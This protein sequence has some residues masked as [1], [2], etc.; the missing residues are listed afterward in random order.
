MIC[1]DLGPSQ[2]VNGPNGSFFNRILSPIAI[3]AGA[4]AKSAAEVA[5]ANAIKKLANQKTPG[6]ATLPAVTGTPS[7]TGIAATWRNL[8][9]WV[10]LTAYAVGALALMKAAAPSGD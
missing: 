9:T 4:D 10:K 8:P 7:A 3:K 5:T 6:S 1:G 2:S